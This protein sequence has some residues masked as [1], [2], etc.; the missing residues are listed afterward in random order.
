MCR[1]PLMLDVAMTLVGC[2]YNESNILNTEYARSFLTAYHTHRPITSRERIL[3]PHFLAYA[4]AA[5]AFWRFRQF[6][7]RVPNVERRNAHQCMVERANEAWKHAQ[8]LI[9]LIPQ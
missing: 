4:C 9:A 3:F 1:G 7:V 6:N 2:A 8:S 5:I